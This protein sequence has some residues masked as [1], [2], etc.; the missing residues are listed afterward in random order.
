MSRTVPFSFVEDEI[1]DANEVTQDF[2][3]I[4]SWFGDLRDADFA[5][6][7]DLDGNKLSATSGKRIPATRLET[8]AATDRVVASDTSSPGSDSLRAV[9]GDHMKA[10]T[11]AAVARI[12]PATSI[13]STMLAAGAA[14]ANL[15]G[16]VFGLDRLKV[17]VHTVAFSVP[18]VASGVFTVVAANPTST[19][20]TA[21]Y[22]LVGVFAKTVS[23][24]TAPVAFGMAGVSGANWAGSVAVSQTA[25]PATVAGTL[26]YV[27]ILRT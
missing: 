4:G 1:A 20:T 22:E 14:L 8:N 10:L 7:A 3:T 23:G 25:A 24:G 9:S 26:V 5:T 19:F 17:T 21:L 16:A 11:V 27:F 6:D 18:G 15:V 2:V 13:L 12:I